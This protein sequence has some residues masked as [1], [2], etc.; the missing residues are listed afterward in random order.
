MGRGMLVDVSKCIACRSCQVACKQWWKLPAVPSVNRGTHENPADLTA[1]T[2]NRIAFRE[3]ESNRTKKWLFTRKSCN[4]C[5][6]AACVWVCPSFA[7]GYNNLGSVTIDETRCI[8][9]GRC[10]EYCPFGVPRLG[11]HNI[12]PKI[13][14][15]LYTPR[16][17]S[18]S[19]AFCRDRLE[20][21]G[22][23]AC[24]KSCPTQAILFGEWADL[25]KR[26][27]ARVN[28]LRDSHPKANLYGEKEMGGLRVLKVLTEE[29]GVHGL[30]EN[31]KIGD[32]PEYSQHNF[33]RWYARAVSEGLLPVFPAKANRKWYMQPDLAPGPAP[34]EPE[35]TAGLAGSK[36]GGWAPILGGWLGVG[37]IGTL[38]A[39]LW[40]LRRR[41]TVK[42]EEERTKQERK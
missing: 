21:G 30:P 19:C 34:K 42:G 35:L 33:P 29:P 41:N 7:R 12:S 20:N 23:P 13:A 6:Q 4:H 3:I 40:N 18:Y 37:V 27:R 32:P 22:I 31:P 25:V 24:A 14:V 9:C 39:V 1:H 16:L 5:S 38:S 2:W 10:G 15:G 17:V 36:L 11:A 8:G 26:G 28:A